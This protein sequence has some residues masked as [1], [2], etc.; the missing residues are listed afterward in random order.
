MGGSPFCS[1][2]KEEIALNGIPDSPKKQVVLKEVNQTLL[3]KLGQSM[4]IKTVDFSYP[5]ELRMF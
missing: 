3:H 2:N 1:L 5:A 4:Q